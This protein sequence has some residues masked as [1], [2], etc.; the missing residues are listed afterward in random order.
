[1]LERARERV[2]GLAG[3]A[4]ESWRSRFGAAR[5]ADCQPDT[6]YPERLRRHERRRSWSCRG[7]WG[8]HPVGQVSVTSGELE[9]RPEL[10]GLVDS[11]KPPEAATRLEF[12]AGGPTLRLR[13]DASAWIQRGGAWARVEGNALTS[14]IDPEERLIVRFGPK[15]AS[16]RW[17]FVEAQPPW[18]PPP[19]R[20][21]PQP[22]A[23]LA[24][25]LALTLTSAAIALI[26]QHTVPSTGLEAAQAAARRLRQPV[27]LAPREAGGRRSF[28]RPARA[29][30]L[31]TLSAH[32]R[33]APRLNVERQSSLS[34]SLP[35]GWM[36]GSAGDMLSGGLGVSVPVRDAGH[37]RPVVTSPENV[38]EVLRQNRAR[39]E[40]CY[41]QAASRGVT[42]WLRIQWM[43][44]P[45]G[46]VRDAQLLDTT[47][48]DRRV[49]ACFVEALTQLNFG[50]VSDT[51]GANRT[52]TLR[53]QP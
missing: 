52:F 53:P 19:R 6:E 21:L 40:P 44:A 32:A 14:R 50:P 43:I 46:N 42:G 35:A 27:T 9:R 1:M 12:G 30:A 10:A 51:F 37:G 28:L 4:W 39:F 38:G 5:R 41:A 24:A 13:S 34:H 18:A 17:L 45:G 47:L 15:H 36:A 33:A 49:E 16:P 7:S 11:A 23:L 22:D 31:G 29:Q 2:A 8:D 25:A 20:L 3:R 48:G 26:A